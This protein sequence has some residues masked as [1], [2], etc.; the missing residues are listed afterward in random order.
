MIKM[1]ISNLGFQISGLFLFFLFLLLIAV[2]FGV[3]AATLYLDP[4]KVTLGPDNTLE[5]KVKIGVG[6]GECINAVQV[7]IDFPA[8]ILEL[9]D[10][11]SGESLISLW[12]PKAPDK[13]SLKI[14]NGSGKI[15]FSGGTPGG[16]CG[17]IPG[18]PGDSNILGSLIFTPKKPII[19]HQAILGFSSETQLFLN[20]GQGTLAAL[21]TQGAVLA[22]DEKIK[23]K[24]DDWKVK[25]DADKTPPEPFVVEISNSPRIANGKYFAVFFT[26]DKETGIDR[27]EILEA[28]A[29]SLAET[30]Y[31][32]F[33]KFLRRIFKVKSALSPAW[34]K[35]GSPYVLKDQTLASVLK[36]KAVDRAGNERVV[37]FNETE[38][39]L[40]PARFPSL[41]ELAVA[42]IVLL[43]LALAAVLALAF[44]KRRKRKVI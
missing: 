1:K 24:S 17:K 43:F 36:I 41:Q 34:E 20:D 30:E 37:E 40:A 22:I 26:T 23:Q 21:N 33:E 28:S 11:N 14:A 6:S 19:S 13:D 12:V 18:D 38:K 32:S 2:P 25:L 27:Y 29:Q 39:V 15:I 16:Y 35:T 31:G 42:A 4:A 5:V 3:S 8:D 7:G 9:K 44:W 10:F